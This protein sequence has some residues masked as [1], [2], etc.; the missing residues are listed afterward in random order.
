MTKSK[1]VIDKLAKIF[2]QGLISYKDLSSE[3]INV[4]KSKRDE[5]VFKMKLTSKEEFDVLTKRV[6]NL[7]KKLEQFKKSKLKKK[8]TKVKKP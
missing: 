8:I 4:L 7:E 1:F 5:I 2:E 3:I 6:E